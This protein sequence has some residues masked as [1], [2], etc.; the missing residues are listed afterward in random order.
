[1]QQ[2]MGSLPSDRITS[3]ARAFVNTGVDFAGP[4]S[5]KT[6]RGRGSR[7]EKAWIALF[8]CLAVK[9]VHLELVTSLSTEAFIATLKRFIARRGKPKAMYSDNGTNFV[10]ARKELRRLIASEEH[11]DKVTTYLQQDNVE[12]HFIP[13]RGSHF[14]GLW[15]A[16]IKSMKYHLRRVLGNVSLAYEEMYTTLCQIEACLNSRPLTPLSSS[17]TDLQPLTPGHFLIT[18][19]LNQLPEEDLSEVKLQQ[20]VKWRKEKRNLQKNDLVILKEENTPP[21]KWVLGRVED[22]HFGQDGKCRV[23]TVKTQNGT[24][25]RPISKLVLI[26]EEDE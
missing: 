11:N 24:Y 9:A 17:P 20:R 13:Q 21:A 12:W 25:T 19:P 23:V 18:T 1:M 5:L 6:G 2:I 26:L 3:G 14:G 15:E 22:L 10:G 8:V 7:T 4:V 16:G